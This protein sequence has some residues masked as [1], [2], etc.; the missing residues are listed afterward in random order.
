MISVRRPPAI[1]EIV[2]KLICAFGQDDAQKGHEAAIGATRYEPRSQEDD[3]PAM[4][5]KKIVW[6]PR[7]FGDP[8]DQAVII[9]RDVVQ[10]GNEESH[11]CLGRTFAD[12]RA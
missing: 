7:L 8:Q 1:S 5:V 4:D 10:V 3:E 6:E 12:A 11:S 2:E 9:L